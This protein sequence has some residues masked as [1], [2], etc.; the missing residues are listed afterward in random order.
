MS[1]HPAA[2]PP[3]KNNSIAIVALVLPICVVTVAS[4]S[5]A[6]AQQPRVVALTKPVAELTETFS[7]ISSMRELSDGRVIVSDGRDKSLQIVNLTSQ[8]VTKIGRLGSGPGEYQ[9]VGSLYALAGDTT[10]LSDFANSRYLVITPDGKAGATRAFI[11]TPFGAATTLGLDER[12]AIYLRV[13][14]VAR[15]EGGEHSV[16]RF[17][18]TSKHADIISTIMRPTGLFSGAK[19]MGGGMLKVFTNLPFAPEDAV[20]LARDGRVA[21]ARFDPYHIEWF[22]RDGKKTS[23]PVVNFTPIE[24]NTAEKRA[25]MEKQVRPGTITVQNGA[26]GNA[27]PL[28]RQSSPKV[29][30]AE[31]TYDDKGM[32]WPARKP[33]FVGGALSIDSEGRA[34]VLRTTAHTVTQLQFDVFDINAK[35]IFTVVLP[36]KTKLAGFGATSV[37]LA[38]NDEDDLQHLQ[39]YAAPQ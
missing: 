21:V 35:L 7:S 38:F 12:G 29:V 26:T 31:D 9:S 14:T 39:R 3:M 36:P 30:F 13:P 27:A 19:S 1:R 15:E 25:F 11:Q 22:A 16:V 28:S 8:S 34:W 37:Y 6:V 23:G 4:V 24:I 17:D 18:A 2:P 10:L 33:P 5:S 20:A 32:T